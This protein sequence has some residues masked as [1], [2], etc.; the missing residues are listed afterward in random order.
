MLCAS[1]PEPPPAVCDRCGQVRRRYLIREVL[2]PPRMVALPFGAGSVKLL[3]AE[4]W[5]GL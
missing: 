4:A 5:E 3:D 1:E 2:G